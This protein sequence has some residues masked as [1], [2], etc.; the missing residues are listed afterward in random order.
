MKKPCFMYAAGPGD[1]VGTFKHWQAR[2]DDDYQPAVTYSAQFFD[3]CE[4]MDAKGV[5]VSSCSRKET[6]VDDRFTVINLPKRKL[7]GAIGYH[8]SQV[9]YML[10]IMSLAAKFGADTLILSDDTGHWFPLRLFAPKGMRIVSSF[11]CTLWPQWQPLGFKQRLL[12]ML[13]KLALRRNIDA[14]LCVSEDIANQLSQ[15]AGQSVPAVFPFIPTYRRRFFKNVSQ[16]S[17]SGPFNVLFVGRLEENKGVLDLLAVSRELANRGRDDIMIHLCGDGSLAEG[18]PDRIRESGL[19]DHIRFHGYCRREQVLERIREAHVFI[20]PTTTQF[21]EG[22]NKV[23]V[24]AILSGR[25]VITTKVCPALKWVRKAALEVQPG[26]V[27][28]FVEAILLLADHPVYFNLK[29]RACE[30]YREPFYTDH[31][32]W[33]NALSRALGFGPHSMMQMVEEA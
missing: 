8:L 26:N 2:H 3:L 9:L 10:Q 32:S 29:Q 1:V 30:A 15:V 16:P 31:H 18:L 24:E 27:A 13:N 20:V 11:H 19:E 28:A 17:D 7:P 25:P 14:A 12:N 21:S 22:F 6:V 4:R 33:G 23:V 5:A